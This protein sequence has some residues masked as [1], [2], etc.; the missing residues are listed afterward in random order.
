MAKRPDSQEKILQ[1]LMALIAAEGWD[2]VSMNRVAR[3]AKVPVG[4]LRRLYD[5][6]QAMLSDF[7]R[8]IDVSV[9]SALDPAD[10]GETHRD[11]LFDVMMRRFDALGPHKDALRAL[12]RAGPR[13]PVLVICSGKGMVRS[14]RWMLDAAGLNGWG[15]LGGVRARLLAGVY[16]GL[17][18]VWLDDESEDQ[19][20]TMAALDR[21]LDRLEG[22]RARACRW[23]WRREAVA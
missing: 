1:A 7:F 20:K 11:R 6:R 16:L 12:L 10:E 22:L 15:P 18:R 23:P 17:M 14:M 13:D 2:A 3:D 21:A 4:D 8:R 5:G 19:A 9:L